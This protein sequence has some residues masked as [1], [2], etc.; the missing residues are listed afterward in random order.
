[1]SESSVLQATAWNN[2][3]KQAKDN[4]ERIAK[5]NPKGLDDILAKVDL[6]NDAELE[7]DL[8]DLKEVETINDFSLQCFV[9]ESVTTMHALPATTIG[10]DG[11]LATFKIGLKKAESVFLLHGTKRLN[12]LCFAT[13]T[14]LDKEALQSR[15]DAGASTFNNLKR[16]KEI[17]S[18]SDFLKP[19]VGQPPALLTGEQTISFLRSMHEFVGGVVHIYRENAVFVFVC[20]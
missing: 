18:I 10:I 9:G 8:A 19:V 7:Q 15:F 6:A 4:V 2:E 1:M 13:E 11:K 17:C 14:T 12:E 20:Y 3:K 5:I 16:F